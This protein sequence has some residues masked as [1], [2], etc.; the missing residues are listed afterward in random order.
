MAANQDDPAERQAP[1]DRCKPP[2]PGGSLPQ[3]GSRFAGMAPRSNGT[4]KL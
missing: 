3:H 1:H 4:A 2:K